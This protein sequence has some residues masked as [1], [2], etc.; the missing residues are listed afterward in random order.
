MYEYDTTYAGRGGASELE[1]E[2][3]D[4]DHQIRE[5]QHENVLQACL[6]LLEQCDVAM[7]RRVR[8]QMSPPLA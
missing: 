6:V 8:D 2:D 1:E 7:D 4:H 3:S 5:A